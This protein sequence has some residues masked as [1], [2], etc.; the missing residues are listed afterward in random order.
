MHFQFKLVQI[1][2]ASTEIQHFVHP[3]KQPAALGAGTVG[4][5]DIGFVC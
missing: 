5:N 3:R 4:D 2:N 1:Y